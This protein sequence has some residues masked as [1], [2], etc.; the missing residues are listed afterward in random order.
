[1]KSASQNIFYFIIG[2]LV[3]VGVPVVAWGVGDV[4]AY[5]ANIQRTLY[6]ILMTAATL[7]VVIFVPNQ[8]RGYK[9][10]EKLIVRQKLAVLYLQ[11][12]SILLLV[13]S[14]IA[15]KHAFLSIGTGAILRTSGLLLTMVGYFLMSWSIMVLGKQFSVD[16]TIQKDHELITKRPYSLIRHPRYLGIIIFLSGISLVFNSWLSII[17]VVLTIVVLLWRI[18]DEEKLMQEEFSEKWNDYVRQTKR[19]IPYVY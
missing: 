4:G 13:I 18:S 11:A 17:M 8:G 10:G 15:D 6:S 14:P 19:L 12:A 2:S 7:L 3:F 5:F 16:V 1:M 9:S